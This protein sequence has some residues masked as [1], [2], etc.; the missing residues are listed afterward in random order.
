MAII[1]VSDHG[2]VM[3]LLWALWWGRMGT[4]SAGGMAR[5][6]PRSIG[7]WGASEDPWHASRPGEM[8]SEA[9]LACPRCGAEMSGPKKS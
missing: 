6:L 4:V 7:S 2:H 5:M 8:G 3:F 9:L 1:M